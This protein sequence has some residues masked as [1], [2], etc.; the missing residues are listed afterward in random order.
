MKP[1]TY[2]HL[3]C[4][5]FNPSQRRGGQAL[6]RILPYCAA[7][8]QCAHRGTM[9]LLPENSSSPPTRWLGLNDPD[10]TSR[11]TMRYYQDTWLLAHAVGSG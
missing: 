2:P 9:R 6:T 7:T 10:R 8:K 1:I 5:S 11:R 3:G 4:C